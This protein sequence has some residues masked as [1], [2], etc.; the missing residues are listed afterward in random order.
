MATI[1]IVDDEP[2]LHELYGDVLKIS[3]HEIVAN[4]YDGDEAVEIFKKMNEPPEVVI[5][6]HRMPGKNG[7]ETTKEI[8]EINPD[9]KILFASADAAIKNDALASGACDFLSKPFA[10]GDL[11]AEIEEMAAE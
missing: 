2:M 4:A 6:D 8:L 7:I 11:L 1:F 3:G 10:I 5:M 9:I